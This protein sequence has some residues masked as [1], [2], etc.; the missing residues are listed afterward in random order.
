MQNK[1]LAKKK[2]KKKEKKE[3]KK[4]KKYKHQ[5]NILELTWSAVTQVYSVFQRKTYFS[6]W[7][8]ELSWGARDI[9]V[10]IWVWWVV[11]S[12]NATGLGG[13]LERGCV[14]GR[15]RYWWRQQ[16]SGGQV[17]WG[18][19]GRHCGARPSAVGCSRAWLRAASLYYSQYFNVFLYWQETSLYHQV[20][21]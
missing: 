8:P 4:L 18:P 19:F 9:S 17:H 14:A 13:T 12:I 1:Y 2:K 21:P 7:C 6:S 11:R 15:E 5:K 16:E 20:R 3:K 10:G